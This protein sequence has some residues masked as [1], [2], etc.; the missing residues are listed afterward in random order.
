MHDR[1]EAESVARAHVSG[2]LA[3][4]VTMIDQTGSLDER[5]LAAIAEH[6]RTGAAAKIGFILTSRPENDLRGLFALRPARLW[7]FSSAQLSLSSS[8][9]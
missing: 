6:P 9:P 2:H 1:L 4:Q 5:A 3:P 8:A 7:H